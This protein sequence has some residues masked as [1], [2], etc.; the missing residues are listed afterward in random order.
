MGLRSGASLTGR[1]LDSAP[2]RASAV[3][4]AVVALA[5]VCDIAI[6]LPRH[7]HSMPKYAGYYLDCAV[8]LEWDRAC[9]DHGYVP[10]LTAVLML[11]L[12]GMFWDRTFGKIVNMLSR[13]VSWI[14][15][16]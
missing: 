5:L 13:A 9:R 10:F 11:A 12:A 15:N 2:K 3:L 1:F 7:S 6:Y 8:G 16:G 4:F 14:R